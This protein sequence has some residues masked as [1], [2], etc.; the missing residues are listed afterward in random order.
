[1]SSFK[2]GGIVWLLYFRDEP[3]SDLRL[4]AIGEQFR[5]RDETGIVGGEEQRLLIGL[6]RQ[7]CGRRRPV[8]DFAHNA[9]PPTSDGSKF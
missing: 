2:D 3:R 6:A 4:A 5:A 9:A 8:R 1:M 7:S